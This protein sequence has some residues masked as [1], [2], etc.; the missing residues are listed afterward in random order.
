[1]ELPHL[2]KYFF[3]KNNPLLYTEKYNIYEH[4]YN[5]EMIPINAHMIVPELLVVDSPSHRQCINGVYTT[6]LIT[7]Q[8]KINTPNC[9][10]ISWKIF[11]RQA[12]ITRH[13][14]VVAGC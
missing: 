9:I 12:Y 4:L 7:Q 5:F 8:Y 1:M 13:S 11:T 14:L 6:W 10:E 2:H 3:I